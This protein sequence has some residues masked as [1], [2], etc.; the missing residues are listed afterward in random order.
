MPLG[1]HLTM[2]TLPSGG[3]RP[4]ADDALPPSLD[5]T[6]LIRAPEGLQ[7]SRT[8]RCSAHTMPDA[9]F[10]SAARSPYRHLSRRSGT[11]QISW[12]KRSP[13]PCTIAEST[14]RTSM[15]YGLRG[16]LPTRPV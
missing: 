16:K 5:M 12:G 1:F 8:T 7:P 10:C 14:L 11:E 13:L 15:D 6:P 9:D 4:P 2:D 3:L